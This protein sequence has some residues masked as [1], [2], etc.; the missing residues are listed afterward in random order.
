MIFKFGKHFFFRAHIN[1]TITKRV[2][3]RIIYFFVRLN[4][5]HDFMCF[6]IFFSN[7]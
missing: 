5:K 3:I 1:A 4:S 2:S 7:V 6:M